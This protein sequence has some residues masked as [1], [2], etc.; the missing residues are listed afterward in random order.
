[1]LARL[2]CTQSGSQQGWGL[3][4]HRQSRYTLGISWC[5]PNMKLEGANH[6]GKI[7]SQGGS[8]LCVALLQKCLRPL[9][10]F[11]PPPFFKSFFAVLVFC[12]AETRLEVTSWEG[13]RK[14]QD[15]TFSSK[16]GLQLLMWRE[17]CKAAP[18]C[19]L[20]VRLCSGPLPLSSVCP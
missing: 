2:V 14:V 7:H 5:I 9:A 12:P 10:T 17:R 13:V 8:E 16:N 18:L 15:K 1:M 3:P 20:A 19:H 6:T 4:L 11:L